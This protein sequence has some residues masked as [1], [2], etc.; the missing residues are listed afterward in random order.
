M[1]D[2]TVQE[3][4][5]YLQTK[6]ILTYLSEP[7]IGLL[8]YE[9]KN[10]YER[11]LISQNQII[12]RDNNDKFISEIIEKK[13]ANKDK[14]EEIL[15]Y[16]SN[17]TVKFESPN[18]IVVNEFNKTILIKYGI[19]SKI[20]SK[21]RYNIFRQTATNKDILNLLLRYESIIS[22]S[23]QW[24]IPKEC[25]DNLIKRFD[26]KIEAFASP[27]NSQLLLHNNS[28]LNYCS[29]FEDTDKIFRSLGD[30]YKNHFENCSIIANPPYVYLLLNK[31][32]N[33]VI[34]ECNNAKKNN[35]KIRYFITNPNWIDAEFYLL[36]TNS[37]FMSYKKILMKNEYYYMDSNCIL[38]N[39]CPKKIISKF[40]TVIFVMSYGYNDNYEGIFEEY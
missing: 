27:I 35:Y 20:I 19:F 15:N 36:Y 14:A 26:I 16:I 33:Y 38:D 30:F 22:T 40:E 21:Q 9:I 29:L 31:L 3:Y 39:G 2:Q 13:I 23:Q 6:Q 7:L 10:I 1:N 28:N 8:K 37:E 5:K 24:N 34:Q 25:F 17:F 12:T 32:A 18:K 4:A 11:W